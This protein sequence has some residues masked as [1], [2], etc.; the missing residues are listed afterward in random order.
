MALIISFESTLFIEVLI[1]I[2]KDFSSLFILATS[3]GGL[4]RP[5]MTLL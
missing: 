2:K 1:Y 4:L 3:S 5:D